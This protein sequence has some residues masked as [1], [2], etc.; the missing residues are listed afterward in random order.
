M[1]SRVGRG[2][3]P[4][5]AGG[6]SIEQHFC[7]QQLQQVAIHRSDIEVGIHSLPHEQVVRVGEDRKEYYAR[8]PPNH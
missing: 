6:L 1:E 8:P 5:E 2:S 7:H 4:S 3:I